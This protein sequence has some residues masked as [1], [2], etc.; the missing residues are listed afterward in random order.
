MATDAPSSVTLK[1]NA[2]TMKSILDGVAMGTMERA[3]AHDLAVAQANE[4]IH[5]QFQ[6]TVILAQAAHVDLHVT[7]WVTAKQEDL[8]V[9]TANEWISWLEGPG[10]QTCA[11]RLCKY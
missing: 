4:E 8:L 7:D 5:K 1:L 11:G 9:K 10:S 2:E 6:E 3:D